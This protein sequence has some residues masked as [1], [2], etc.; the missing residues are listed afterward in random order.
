MELNITMFYTYVLKSKKDDKLYIGWTDDLKQ[1][2][3]QHNTGKVFA[4]KSRTP[5]QLVYYEACVHKE[6]AIEREE[7]FKTGFG[8]SFLKKRI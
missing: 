4:T 2:L 1:R 7:Y 8:K 5:F 6:K 3:H